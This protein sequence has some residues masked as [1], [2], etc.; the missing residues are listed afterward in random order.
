MNKQIVFSVAETKRDKL[1]HV[2][3]LHHIAYAPFCQVA[4]HTHFTYW[5][6]LKSNSWNSN[7]ESRFPSHAT[8]VLSVS[9]EVGKLHHLVAKLA[10]NLYKFLEGADSFQMVEGYQ[11]LRGAAKSKRY[12]EWQHMVCVLLVQPPSWPTSNVCRISEGGVKMAK[13]QQSFIN[14]VYIPGVN[15]YF[16]SEP[17]IT[18]IGLLRFNLSQCFYADSISV[19][20]SA[21]ALLWN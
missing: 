21:S 14:H 8:H 5:E 6:L 4:P 9:C 17:K 7:T 15:P 19:L 12:C 2:H 1:L 10:E 20:I 11:D 3:Q 13:L 16:T 18:F